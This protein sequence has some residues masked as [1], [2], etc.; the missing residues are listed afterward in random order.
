LCFVR[1]VWTSQGV[2]C[3]PWEIQGAT[4]PCRLQGGEVCFFIFFSRTSEAPSVH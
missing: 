3:L 2:Y 1:S 4:A